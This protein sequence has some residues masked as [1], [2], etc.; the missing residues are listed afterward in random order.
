MKNVD[1]FLFDKIPFIVFV[2]ILMELMMPILPL[3]SP[4]PYLK[5]GI[6]TYRSHL[7]LLLI[8]RQF[9]FAHKI[10]YTWKPV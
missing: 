6:L 7:L 4:S 5:Q 9:N 8:A 3:S 10:R 2:V 1:K